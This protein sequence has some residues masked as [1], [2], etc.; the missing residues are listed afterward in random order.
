MGASL[1]EPQ[2]TGVSLYGCPL[3]LVVFL[4]ELKKQGLV[5]HPHNISNC[6]NKKFCKLN[7]QEHKSKLQ[8]K[9]SKS[10][11]E[12]FQMIRLRFYVHL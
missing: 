10:Q 7:Q 12:T 9:L 3:I 11:N 4:W 8:Q 5:L 1:Q 6:Q 2:E